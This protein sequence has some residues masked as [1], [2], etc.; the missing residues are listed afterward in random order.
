MKGNEHDLGKG[1]RKTGSLGEIK[2]ACVF[3]IYVN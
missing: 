2:Q 3:R 1:T